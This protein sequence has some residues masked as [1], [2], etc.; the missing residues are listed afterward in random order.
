MGQPRRGR[1]VLVGASLFALGSTCGDENPPLTGSYSLEIFETQDTCDNE[2]NQFRSEATIS[3]A[4]DDFELD[5]GEQ[6]SLPAVLNDEGVFV[7]E[8]IIE[9]RG[10]GQTTFMRIELLIRRGDVVD[11][12]GRITY[13][14]TFPGVPGE[15][16]QR[17][18]ALGQRLGLAPLL[19][20][21]R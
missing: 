18:N 9:D 2:A 21:A 12:A 17:F 6:A 8:G 1:V 4:G 20:G 5:F 11:G 7:A 14:G 16:E 13:H 10:E 3:R 19:G 15:C